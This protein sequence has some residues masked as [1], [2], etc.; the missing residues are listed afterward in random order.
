MEKL[1][2][3]VRKACIHGGPFEI[4]PHEDAFFIII[5]QAYAECA[6]LGTAIHTQIKLLIESCLVEQILIVI[7]TVESWVILVG[8]HRWIHVALYFQSVADIYSHF[9]AKQRL[10][11]LVVQPHFLLT[12]GLADKYPQSVGLEIPPRCAAEIKARSPFGAA[13]GFDDDYAI[14]P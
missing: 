6:L 2:D 4:K 14:R 10:N 8:E 11:G 1:I 7:G 5:A 13:F 3:V 12:L 9:V